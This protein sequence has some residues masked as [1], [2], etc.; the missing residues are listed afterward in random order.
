MSDEEFAMFQRDLKNSQVMQHAHEP[1]NFDGDALLVVSTKGEHG[2]SGSR[3][4]VERWRAYISGEISEVQ[5]PCVHT[6]LMRP[7]MLAKAWHGISAWLGLD[8]D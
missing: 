4:G 7:E 2:D 3:L 1:R 8:I 5:V 6:Q